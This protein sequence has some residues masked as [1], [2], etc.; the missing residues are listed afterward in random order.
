MA[1]FNLFDFIKT[2]ALLTVTL[3]NNFVNSSKKLSR[4]Q[5]AQQLILFLQ[6]ASEDEVER[7]MLLKD[8]L[9]MNLEVKNT[10]PNPLSALAEMLSIAELYQ[11]LQKNKDL[12]DFLYHHLALV[13]SNEE[14]KNAEDMQKDSASTDEDEFSLEKERAS[15]PDSLFAKTENLEESLRS[16]NLEESLQPVPLKQ[17]IE[18]FETV[19]YQAQ[20]LEPLSYHVI[21]VHPERQHLIEPQ[22]FNS[23]TQ[24]NNFVFSLNN[25][26]EKA[27]DYYIAEVQSSNITATKDALLKFQGFNEEWDWH[28]SVNAIQLTAKCIADRPVEYSPS[29]KTYESVYKF[30]TLDCG[31]CLFNPEG[32]DS[33]ART[34]KQ[35]DAI[36]ERLE[37][38]WIYLILEAFRMSEPG[39]TQKKIE[40]LKLL[41]NEVLEHKETI[42]KENGELKK[43]LESGLNKKLDKQDPTNTNKVK[44]LLQQQRLNF[45]NKG[46]SKTEEE[47][48]DLIGSSR[49]KS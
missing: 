12:A 35:L 10:M 47:I 48:D 15:N 13:A 20:T 44:K 36:I 6:D 38:Q 41:K 2:S 14:D 9:N 27:W 18:M 39:L 21:Y 4:T 32:R 46:K 22:S 11:S 24:A 5:F 26:T 7:L 19:K 17:L 40:A 3:Q 25:N 37:G 16:Q 8:N 49:P 34:I 29:G 43:V 1:N 28:P 42:E 33:V 31:K 45:F 30:T 23:Y